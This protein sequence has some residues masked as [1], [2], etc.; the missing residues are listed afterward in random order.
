MLAV[1][2]AHGDDARF[3]VGDHGGRLPEPR[4]RR[5]GRHRRRNPR[6][7]RSCGRWCRRRCRCR[8]C[9][10]SPLRN[11]LVG[12]AQQ[13]ADVLGQ[14]F[15]EAVVGVVGQCAVGAVARTAPAAAARNA[16]AGTDLAARLARH[17][18]VV[19]PV[20]AQHRR[21]GHDEQ[22]APLH[23]VAHVHLQGGAVQDFGQGLVDGVHAHR[24]SQVRVH[25]QVQARIARN[26]EQQAA[27]V[28][29]VH[30]DGKHVGLGPRGA[31]RGRQQGR[32]HQRGRLSLRRSLGPQVACPGRR[33]VAGAG[34]QAQGQQQYQGS[35]TSCGIQ[36]RNRVCTLHDGTRSG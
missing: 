31:G 13:I 12:F 24:A 10:L 17:I 7:R 5:G 22:V 18:E 30:A 26:G 19:H 6:R 14:R 34:R 28:H 20:V 27:D 35:Q 11:D 36:G 29:V 23:L 33:C 15:P 21:I 8:C 2:G 3:R 4:G 32:I 25:V 16:G 9:S 1:G